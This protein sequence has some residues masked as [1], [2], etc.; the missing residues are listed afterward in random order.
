MSTGQSIDH[1][2]QIPAIEFQQ[3]FGNVIDNCPQA[4]IEI[5]SKRPFRDT[6]DLVEHFENYLTDVD[7]ES[8]EKILQLAGKLASREHLTAESIEEQTSAGLH[9]LSVE[10]RQQLNEMNEMYT[11]KYGFQFVICVRETNKIDGILCGITQ[12]LHNERNDE[13]NTAINEM[14]K[15]C[16]LRIGQIIEL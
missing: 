15:I 13:L 4:A 12:R 5:S 1:L 14:K 10:Q 8:K 16:R 9:L 2:N 11:R 3:I 6:N 7:V